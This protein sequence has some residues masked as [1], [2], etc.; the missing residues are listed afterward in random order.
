MNPRR[1]WMCAALALL[2]G[3]SETPKTQ[4]AK[5]P[6]KPAE[7]VTGR[8]AFHQVYITARTWGTDLQG[9]RVVPLRVGS[10]PA[11]P[12]KSYAWEVTFVSP[13]KAKQRTYIYSVI[14][15]GSILKGTV[16]GIEDNYMQRGQ[17]RPW[18]TQ[19]FKI[20]SDTAYET[21]LNKSQAYVKKN[22]D[23][24]VNFLLEQ[25]PRH[26]EL[27]WRVIWGSSVSTSNYSVYVGASTGLYLETMR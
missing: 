6:E 22:P 8:Y 12:G 15:E 10:E 25:T 23:T 26:P 7:P 13:S 16:A 11:P 3:C 4:K 17:A 1:F 18:N 14:Q 9:L 21:A 20:D 27:T 2:A 24:P 5:E 19:A